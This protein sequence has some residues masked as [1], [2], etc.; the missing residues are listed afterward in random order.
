[1]IR[2]NLEQCAEIAV[3]GEI[4]N[5]SVAPNAENRVAADG[6]V[7]PAGAPAG[8]VLNIKVGDSAFGWAGAD[9]VEPGAAVSNCCCEDSNRAL[10]LLS[11]IGND[12][13][14]TDATFD[15]KDVKLKG[16]AGVVTG[17]SHGRVLVHFPR[18]ILEKLVAGDRL[19]VRSQGNGLKL[20]DYPD[21]SVANI[22]PKL[23]RAMNLS[24]KGGKV[25][26]QVTKIIPSRLVGAGMSDRPGQASHFDIQTTSTE[27]QK[28]VEQVRLGDLVTIT[29]LDSSRGLRYE[30]NAVTVGIVCHGASRRP[31]HGIG[32]NVL[33]SSSKGQ[34]EPIIM[35]KANLAN[36]LSLG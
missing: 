12:A 15:N 14:V 25:R 2:T 29:D 3:S 34:I 21:V 26:V 20:L 16:V 9:E 24:E 17:K 4:C 1:M 22:G 31:G 18:R 32:I 5:P 27:D 6:S 10:E 11:C 7:F 36:Y 30:K 19:Q 13:I 33:L 23:L 28:V 8:I 35:S